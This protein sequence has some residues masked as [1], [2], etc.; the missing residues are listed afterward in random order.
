MA[1][2]TP[3]AGAPQPRPLFYLWVQLVLANWGDSQQSHWDS[4]CPRLR[5]PHAE[6]GQPGDRKQTSLALTAG[7][8]PTHSLRTASRNGCLQLRPD[9][10]PPAPLRR[11]RLEGIRVL[12]C[13]PAVSFRLPFCLGGDSWE[14]LKKYNHQ[15]CALSTR[16]GPERT[17]TRQAVSPTSQLSQWVRGDTAAGPGSRSPCA[18]GRRQNK[19]ACIPASPRAPEQDP[20]PAELC[21]SSPALLCGKPGQTGHPGASRRACELRGRGAGLAGHRGLSRDGCGA[22]RSS[23]ALSCDFCAA[24][25][26]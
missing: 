12:Y 2:G 21:G 10:A 14:L 20:G 11:P 22:G 4:M 17:P 3:P 23:A 19:G 1:L 25:A 8:R 9:P 13:L 16:C 15:H 26:P 7:H 6:R 18:G 24:R 5:E